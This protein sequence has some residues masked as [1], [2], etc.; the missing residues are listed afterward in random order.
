MNDIIQNMLDRHSCRSFTDQPIEQEKLDDLITAA[1]W[2][3]SAMNRQ[4]WGILL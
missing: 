2:A 4:T 1:V 3:P